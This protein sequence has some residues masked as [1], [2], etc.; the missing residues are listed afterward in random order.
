MPFIKRVCIKFYVSVSGKRDELVPLFCCPPEVL[1]KADFSVL[2]DV[3]MI[4]VV[5]WECVKRG[6]GPF[7]NLPGD[8]I[9]VVKFK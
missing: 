1:Q 9:S 6:E 5:C 7:D 8:K 4:A 3:Y 2:S